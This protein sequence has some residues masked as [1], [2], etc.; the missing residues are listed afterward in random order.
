MAG[1]PNVLVFL[2]D[3]QRFDT[4]GVHGNPLGLT[5]NI[6]R[7]AQH[8]THFENA[9]TPNPVC[10][11]ARSALQTGLMPTS[12]GVHVNGIPLAVDAKTIAGAFN[13]A[14]Y[15]TGYIGKW[16]LADEDPVTA[17]HRGGY[18]SWLAADLL[19]FSSDEYRTIVWDEDC[20]PVRLPGYRADALADAII[21]FIA[22]NH[23][24][25]FMLFSSFL[26]P[27]HQNE[28]DDYPAPDGYA[29]QY[30]GRW[31]PPDL[32]TLGGTSAAHLGGYYGQVKR[33]DE[34]IGRINDALKSLGLL[35]DTV[36]VVTSDHG[37]HFKTRNAEY[38]RSC[39]EASIRVP[40]VLHGGPFTAGGRHSELV[41]TVDLPATLFE[42]AGVDTS[43]L[44]GRSLLPLVDR[45]EGAEPWRDSVLIQVSESQ[46]GRALRTARWK[47]SVVVPGDD[48]MHS[49]SS[50]W[51][52][53]DALYDLDA[54]PYELHNLIHEA[55]FDGVAAE[56]RA[57]LIEQIR[58]LEGTETEIR[59]V[60][61]VQGTRTPDTTA[62]T[63][64]IEATRFGHQ[65]RRAAGGA[66]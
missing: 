7:M 12:T 35:D 17:E 23:D 19:E 34:C 29:E 22:D 16:H 52:E 66:G 9:F 50:S 64:P 54:D 4:L 32:E 57:K 60:V 38:K 13:D 59:L 33:L 6:D 15:Q 42:M 58:T 36:V 39:H 2:T 5:P 43:Q 53:E 44:H 51:Y 25:P 18:R 1:K 10:A 20:E 40:F 24:R 46:L 49:A 30:T 37:S 31:M 41:S 62:R 3:Q 8:G 61:R 26:E 27:H 21:R 48:G 47:Y 45:R 63:H 11:P 56:L 65:P 55:A 14:G 28:R